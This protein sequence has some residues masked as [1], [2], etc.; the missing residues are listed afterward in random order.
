VLKKFL[1]I[2]TAVAV[3]AVLVVVVR[4]ATLKPAMRQTTD[5]VIEA[6]PERLARG[7]YLVNHVT[8]CLGC[9]SDHVWEKWASPVRPGTEGMGGFTF[10]ATEGV[11]GRVSA[12][13]ITPDRETGIGNWTDDQIIRAIREGVSHD[14]TALFPMMPYNDLREL[15]DEDVHSIVAYLRTLPPVANQVPERQ[16]DF[17]V[18][19]VVKTMPRPLEEPVATPDR[20]DSVAYGRYLTVIGGCVEC[21]TPR[22]SKGEPLRDQAYTGGWEMI[23]PWGHVV[24]ANLTP[25]PGNYMYIASRDDFI[26]RFKA[27]EGQTAESIDPVENNANTIMPWLAFSGMTEEDLGAIYD[28]LKTLPPVEKKI[29]SF[30]RAGS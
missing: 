2:V 7:E 11:P 30:P 3:L 17:P 24:T 25:A 13:N 10:T 16:L 20:T 19:I 22:G 29:I 27:L 8:D 5:L 12:P 4:I 23:G 18:N 6:T 21:H 1:V 28:F 26:R 15:S 14:G 9:H